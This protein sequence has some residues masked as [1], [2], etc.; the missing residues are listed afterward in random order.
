MLFKVYL[1]C[2]FPFSKFDVYINLLRY[3]PKAILSY[4]IVQKDSHCV[5]NLR[6][7]LK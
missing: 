6:Y 4:Q 3:R 5:L 7:F 1:G 2:K